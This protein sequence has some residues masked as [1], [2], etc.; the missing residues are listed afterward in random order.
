V[1][2]VVPF[3]MPRIGI[4]ILESRGYEVEV[5]L[6]RV[7]PRE[8]IEDRIANADAIIVSP[9][10]AIDR[11]IVEKAKKLK[12]V[13]LFGSGYERIDVKACSERGVCVARVANHVDE[14]AAELALALALAALRRVVEGDRMVRSGEWRQHVPR[15]L[16]GKSIKD[17]IVGIVG[18]GRLGTNVAK[19]F[20]ALG[21]KV[22]YWSRSRKPLVESALGIEYVDLDTLLTISDV[23]VLCL[24]AAPETK[25]FF[26]YEKLSRLKDGAVLVNVS[27]G[28][29]VDEESLV[30]VLRER[31]LF[32]ALDVFETEPLPPNHPL[33]LLR[34]TVLTPHIGGFT[35]SAMK[36][37]AVDVA[38]MVVEYLEK[39]T[40]RIGEPLNGACQG[41]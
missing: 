40:L 5:Y 23:V 13:A 18:M 6:D 37:T 39:G 11:G 26:N 22:V 33:T 21:A 15:E 31:R 2:I 36:K 29:V 1:R 8:W 16:L 17:C 32:A 41:A 35:E 28:S 10:I 25:G 12:L 19:L 14:A 4:E 7:A 9:L 24:A 27:R 38:N 30:K 20:K 3:R 34:N